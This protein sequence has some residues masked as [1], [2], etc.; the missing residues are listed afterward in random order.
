MEPT[1]LLLIIA[2][3]AA[4]GIAAGIFAAVYRHILA[5]EPILNWWFKIGLKYEGRWFYSPVWG[6]HRCISGQLSLWVML[7]CV[8]LP[9]IEAQT[10]QISGLFSFAAY[11]AGICLSLLLGLIFAITAAILVAEITSKVI[12]L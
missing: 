12:N 9:A 11:Y 1:N 2:Q 8:I 5:Y 10:G 7:F 6:C 4:V 3:A